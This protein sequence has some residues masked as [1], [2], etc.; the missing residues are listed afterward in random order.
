MAKQV[1]SAQVGE[2]AAKVKEAQEAIFK[3][4]VQELVL[5]FDEQITEM[6]YD[7]PE[8]P[9]YRRTDFLRTSLM[10]STEAIPQLRDNPGAAIADY[11]GEVVLVINEAEIGDTIY[12]GYTARYGAYVHYGTS[13]MSPR[14]WVTLV[15]QRWAEI[16]AAKA[17]EVK[18]AFG[19]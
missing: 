19:L 7:T 5:Q 18:A 1:F 3:G 10:A 12:L 2:W 17:A 16:V 13:K 11:F 8:S 15:V 4:A 9:S 6:V 14:P